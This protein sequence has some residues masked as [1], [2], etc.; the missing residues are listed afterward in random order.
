MQTSTELLKPAATR[1]Q[2]A[3]GDRS[4]PILIGGDLL[5]DTQ[6]W[7]PQ[8]DRRA[9]ALIVTNT[10]VDARY[11]ASLAETLAPH[12]ARV[13]TLVLPDGEVYKDLAHLNLIFDEL[14]G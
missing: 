1:V 4:Y 11:A 10:T 12:F 6:T 8:A 14:L 3:L 7:A 2:I 9:F 5:R 13:R